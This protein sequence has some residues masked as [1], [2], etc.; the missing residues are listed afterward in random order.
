MTAPDT[1]ELLL[2]AS[3][4][5]RSA[6]GDLLNHHWQR[7]RRMIALRLDRR[8]AARVDPSDVLQQTLAVA[9]EQM[10]DYLRRRPLPF[11]PWLR[12]IAWQRIVDAHRRHL[13][14]GKRSVRREEAMVSDGSALELA[15]RLFPQRHSSPS[16]RLRRRE[17]CDRV[18]LALFQLSERNREVLIL[19]YLEKLSPSEIAAVMDLTETAVSM[20]HARALR[21]LRTL[22]AEFEEEDEP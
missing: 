13:H 7:L 21:Q 22:L 3:E 1:E 16:A 19:R 5:D 20:R 15:G 6:R 17:V 11:Y 14:A 2:R 12:Q 8:V 9:V 18:R 4:G 10:S